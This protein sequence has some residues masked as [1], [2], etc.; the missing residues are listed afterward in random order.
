MNKKLLIAGALATVAVAP[1]AAQKTAAA[2]DLP[3]V[4]NVKALDFKFVAPASIPSGT[5]TFRLQNSGKEPHHLW[6]VRL[7]EGKP[8]FD[9]GMVK[10]VVV[11]P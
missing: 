7:S 11:A 6:I 3:H 2:A 5:T 9:H 4:V 8:H 1:L 10:E